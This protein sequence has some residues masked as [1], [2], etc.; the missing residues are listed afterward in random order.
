MERSSLSWEKLNSSFWFL[1][2][3]LAASGVVLF[4]ITL[5]LDQLFRAD[6]SSLPIIYSGG[7][8]A[9]RAVLATIAGSMITVVTTVFSLTIVALQLASAHYSPRILRNFTSDRGVQMV[10]GVFIATFVYALLILRIIRTPEGKSASSFV[11]IISVTTAVL[12]AFFC[13]G[14]LIYF[15]HHIASL[16]QSSTIVE[17]AHKDAVGS[18]A[19]LDDRGDTPPGKPKAREATAASRG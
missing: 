19:K 16:I 14:L 8:T 15:I 11:P 6:I 12:L 13:V 18:L 7:A 5:S 9:A 4:A 3:L 2:G 10:L 17:S 1:P